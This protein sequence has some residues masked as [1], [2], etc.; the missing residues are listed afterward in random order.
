M[1]FR[2]LE[3]VSDFEQY[4]QSFLFSYEK[5]TESKGSDLPIEYLRASKVV[6]VFDKQDQMVAGYILGTKEPLR[7]LNFIPNSERAKLEVPFHLAWSDCCEVT[8]VWKTEAVSL[9][10]MSM[11]FWPHTLIGVL[12]SGKKILLGH[13]QNARLDKFYTALG[14]ATLY[15]GLSSFG[16][17]SRLFAYHRGQVILSIVGLWIF[18]T[19]RRFLKDAFRKL[20]GK[21]K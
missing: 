14:P 9:L 1:R 20:R 5:R 2:R 8:C 12:K 13:N 15:S 10:F 17:P 18:E 19:P 7:L 3:S 4:R 6:G 11:Y 16:L 21:S